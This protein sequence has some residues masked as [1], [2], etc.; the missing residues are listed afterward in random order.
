MLIIDEGVDYLV[1]NINMVSIIRRVASSGIIAII[2]FSGKVES[3]SPAPPL[4]TGAALGL[5]RDGVLLII[6]DAVFDAPPLRA[7]GACVSF[8]LTRSF[9]PSTSSTTR[10]RADPS[11]LDE[12]QVLWWGGLKC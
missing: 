2:W 7:G 1:Y 5:E 9:Y 4:W 3:E 6:F 11:I 10:V 8:T 12:I